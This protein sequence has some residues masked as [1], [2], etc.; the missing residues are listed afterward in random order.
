MV[1]GT[2]VLGD[3][4]SIGERP[5]VPMPD[6]GKRSEPD[7]KRDADGIWLPV[8][9]C[10]SSGRDGWCGVNIDIVLGSRLVKLAHAASARVTRRRATAFT[11]FRVYY[12]ELYFLPNLLR[13]RSMS[14]YFGSLARMLVAK[15]RRRRS[16]RRARARARA[17][18]AAAAHS[19]PVEQL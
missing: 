4:A 2:W 17:P 11:P 1:N 5:A 6:E 15:E 14:P 13:R 3:D 18:R 16:R 9:G 19:S 12:L 10:W 7:G 8:P